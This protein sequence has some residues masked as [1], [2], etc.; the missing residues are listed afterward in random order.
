[1]KLSK[2]N[3]ACQY[4]RDDRPKW[5][6]CFS[7]IVGEKRAEVNTKTSLNGEFVNFIDYKK[8]WIMDS[9]CSHHMTGI[10]SLLSEL[11]KGKSHCYSR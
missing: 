11:R 4:G 1:M 10:D 6:Q 3:V 5:E 8:D 7:T 9:G 2:E